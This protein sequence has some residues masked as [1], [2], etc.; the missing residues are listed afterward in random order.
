MIGVDTKNGPI[1]DLLT[2]TQHGRHGIEVK[3][4]SLASSEPMYADS[5]TPSSARPDAYTNSSSNKKDDENIVHGSQEIPAHFLCG[6]IV[7]TVSLHLE[8]DGRSSA[9]GSKSTRSRKSSFLKKKND[10]TF[11]WIWQSDC[12]LDLRPM[13]GLFEERNRPNS[14]RILSRDRTPELTYLEVNSRSFWERVRIDSKSQNNGQIPYG[15][16][17]YICH[18]VSSFDNWSI[19]EGGLIAGRMATQSGRQN[20]L[21]HSCKPCEQFDTHSSH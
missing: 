21:L 15:W 12:L 20:L 16:T 11:R 10:E 5:D 13:E 2:A 17:G 18:V 7:T 4:D 6:Q 1:R 9:S 14:A 8:E 19:S 3:T